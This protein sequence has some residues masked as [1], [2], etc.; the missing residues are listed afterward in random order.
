MEVS[1]EGFGL[2]QLEVSIEDLTAS[3]QTEGYRMSPEP[4]GE[5]KYKIVKRIAVLSRKNNWTKELNIVS[6]NE[7]APKYDIREWNHDAGKCGKGAT[8]THEELKNLRSVL[9]QLDLVKD[10]LDVNGQS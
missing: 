9:D 6:W 5:L 2:L 10:E 7:N 1:F 8:L 3:C 4:S